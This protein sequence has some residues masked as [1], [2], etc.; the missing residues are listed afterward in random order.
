[1]RLYELH[2]KEVVEAENLPD[3]LERLV[4]R[5]GLPGEYIA[6]RVRAIPNSDNDEMDELWEV[7]KAG[8]E[9]RIQE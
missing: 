3:A 4:D 2:I 6:P 8:T 1:M 9:V 7:V 5:T